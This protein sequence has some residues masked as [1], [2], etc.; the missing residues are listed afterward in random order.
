MET[1]K[2]M[3]TARPDLNLAAFRRLHAN[4]SSSLFT[5]TWK[6][7]GWLTVFNPARAKLLAYSHPDVVDTETRLKT[8]VRD[9][10]ECERSQRQSLTDCIQNNSLQHL[11]IIDLE[12][13]VAELETKLESATADLETAMNRTAATASEIARIPAL[14]TRATTLQAIAIDVSFAASKNLPT[15]DYYYI[16]LKAS[17][18]DNEAKI[19]R[20]SDEPAARC[21]TLLT[22]IKVM[23]CDEMATILSWL[24][25]VYQTKTSID[26]LDSDLSL[27]VSWSHALTSPQRIAARRNQPIPPFI[28]KAFAIAIEPFVEYTK[29]SL[30]DEQVYEKSMLL[31]ISWFGYAVTQ[32]ADPTS[33]SHPTRL[34]S[35]AITDHIFAFVREREHLLY[36]NVDATRAH[37]INHHGVKPVM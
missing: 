19:A 29:R 27:L 35:E 7:K 9:V 36:S 2:I 20:V 30:D 37:L 34:F 28:K 15:L 6:S 10:L 26:R 14:V 4:Y 16:Q 18:A 23:G 11:R 13:K 24:G 21:L 31:L 22:H 8:W 33:P 5:T 12:N 1:N 3:E 32:S 25:M 17:V